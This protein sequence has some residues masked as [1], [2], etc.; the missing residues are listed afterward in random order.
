MK[1]RSTAIG[2]SYIRTRSVYPASH[3]RKRRVPPIKP[4]SNPPKPS[5]IDSLLESDNGSL[6]DDSGSD[7]DGRFN[8]D[9]GF[10]EDRFNHDD[11][12]DYDGESDYDGGDGGSNC[13][14]SESNDESNIPNH[15]PQPTF[16]GA[17][18]PYYPTYTAAAFSIFLSTSGLS[19]A[20]FDTLLK[21][22]KHPEF[23]VA[24]LP[25]SYKA[26]KQLQAGLPT[27]PIYT[28]KLPIDKGHS[29]VTKDI[30]SSAYHHSIGDIVHRILST[31]S[32]WKDLYFGPGMKVA[33]SSEFW[34]GTLWRESTLFGANSV[35]ANGR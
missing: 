8:N 25:S 19:R 35:C 7:Y 31:P 18:G 2:S 15:R 16:E 28:Q 17:Y 9:G 20:A 1:T 6:G 23:R 32:L 24:D 3:K 21:I 26:C 30:S 27:L 14:D 5:E 10:N 12:S 34:H 29:H 22:I 11:R 33:N 4:I 13:N